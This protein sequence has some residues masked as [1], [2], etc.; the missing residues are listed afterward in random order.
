MKI[1]IIGSGNVGSALALLLRD[2]G[3]DVMFGSRT[4]AHSSTEA[5]MHGVVVILALPYSATVDALPPLA[6]P[7]AGKIVIDATNPLNDDWSPLMLGQET[8]GG[9]EVAK[10][11]PNS[12]VAKAFNT[13]FADIM[14]P[15]GFNRDGQSATG[16]VASDDPDALEI[17]A[18]LARDIGLAPVTITRLSAARFLEALAHLNIEL[19]VGQGG[20]TN[21]AF[22]YHRRK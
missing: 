7:L 10:L 20:G 22:V 19:A 4:G 9:E 17:V 6:E 8:S 21:A 5:A 16:F 15:D 11:L 1:G 13:I 14:L 3:H 12:K 2:A 18:G